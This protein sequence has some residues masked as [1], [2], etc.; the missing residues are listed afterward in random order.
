MKKLLFIFLML[1]VLTG[2]HGLRM[3]VG[4]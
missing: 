4:Y 1:T 2:C 3:G